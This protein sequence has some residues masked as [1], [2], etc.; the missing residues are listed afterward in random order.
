VDVC[1]TVNS[2]FACV[3]YNILVADFLQKA[4]EGLFGWV[5]APRSL[6]IGAST[7]CITLP[8]SH[9]RNLSPLRFTSMAGLAIIGVVFL[10]IMSDFALNMEL[11]KVNLKKHAVHLQI[12]L[13]STLGMCTGAF[14]A[15]YNAPK[16]FQELGSNLG[17][18]VRTVVLSFGTAFTFYAFF[19]VGGL[20]LFGDEVL[21]N[22]L[23]NYPAEDNT[24][25][26][27]A[28]L[29]MAFSIV[30]T[31]PLVFTTGRDSL[32]GLVPALQR[33]GEKSPTVTHVMIT[34]GLC[35]VIAILSCFVEDV[36]TVTGL[37]GATIGSCLCWIFPASIYLKVTAR[38]MPWVPKSTRTPLLPK[39]KAV[40]PAIKGHFALQVYAIAMVA[41]GLLSMGVGIIMTLK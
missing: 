41:V 17:A 14:Q 37:L 25:I 13:F 26:L 38:G 2:F 32:I 23:K 9:A 39:A 34:S 11:S 12:G 21:G 19:A 30:F 10:Y 5:G 1:I 36:S 20:G 22:V 8:L 6:L 35:M 7:A 29:G 40:V 28:W 18:H 24:P 27:M 3:A 4:L 15:H 31:Y 16:I 33:A